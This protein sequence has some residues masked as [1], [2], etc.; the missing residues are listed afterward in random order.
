MRRYLLTNLLLIGLACTVQAQEILVSYTAQDRLLSQ[1]IKD[2]EKDYEVRFAFSPSQIKGKKITINAVDQPIDAFLKEVLRPIKLVHQ[3]VGTKFIS[4]K[5]P[6][7][8]YLAAQVFDAETGETLPYATA[9]L[10]DSFMGGI[11]DLEGKFKLFIDEPLDVEVQFSY[12]GYETETLELNSYK[13]GE[14]IRIDLQPETQTLQEIVIKEY[15]NSGIA[16]DEM[17]SSFKILPQE[18]EVLPGLSE[19]DVLLSAQIISGISS[20]DETASGL[21]IRGSSRDNTFFYWNNIPMYQAAHYFGNISSFIPSSIGEVDIYKNY[22]PVE[23]GNASAGMLKLGSRLDLDGE[24]EYEASLNMTHADFYGRLPFKENYGTIMFAAR[25]SYNDIIATPTFN[26]ISDKL[27]EGTLTEDIQQGLTD[28]NFNYNSNINFSDF[29]VAWKYEPTNRSTWQAALLYSGS[30]LDYSS[31]FDGERSTQSHNV[32]NLGA[33]VSLAH[34]LQENMGANLSLTFANYTMEYALE[35]F[36]EEDTEDDND[37]SVINNTIL[38][39]EFRS[40]IDWK[41]S[42]NKFL[43]FGYQFN[44]L[45]VINEIS[46]NLFFEEDEV[47]DLNANGVINAIFGEFDW[48]LSERL[49]LITGV[50]L[51][52]YGPTAEFPVDSQLRLNYQATNDLIFKATLGR[53]NQYLSAVNDSEFSFSNTTEQLW[54]LADN[55]SERVPFI[56]NDQVSL[57]FLFKKD[58]WLIDFDLFS[59]EVSGIQARNLGFTDFFVITESGDEFDVEFAEGYETIDGLDLTILKRWE[60]LRAWLSYNY[61]DSEVV[62]DSVSV[63]P[64]QSPLNQKHQLQLSTT[65][66]T[67]PLE[68]SL[69]YTYKSGLPYTPV[70]DIIPITV[71]F[72]EFDDDDDEPEIEEETFYIREYGDINSRRLKEYHRF[73]ASVWYKF[74]GGADRKWSGELGLSFLNIFNRNNINLRTFDIDNLDEEDDTIPELVSRDRSLLGFTPNLSL[75]IRF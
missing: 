71:Q 49:E 54:T 68:F 41:I 56:V 4:V 70:T 12:L 62:L 26:S 45:D 66:T 52:Q 73:D 25:R 3:L 8:V 65:Y 37:V 53:Y 42:Q 32:D 30:V 14:E 6:E 40:T 16:S 38:N 74:G 29:N 47:F 17:A 46:E 39:L 18:M 69:G 57:G 21:N 24:K 72:E 55:E 7:S 15:V 11:S 50:R 5:T 63:R 27:F 28:G 60:K 19:R 22:V 64:F 33:N 1:V 61:Q 31:S 43:S 67:G 36:R 13:S 44:D 2:L 34:R 20:N 48:D 51:N 23:Y 59:K 75:R 58:S 10:K 9:R 35:N